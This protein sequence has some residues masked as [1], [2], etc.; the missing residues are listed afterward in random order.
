MRS[1]IEAMNA[2][3]T[4]QRLGGIEDTQFLTDQGLSAS[5]IA[6][7]L[8]VTVRTVERYRQAARKSGLTSSGDRA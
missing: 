8:G 1:T 7:R 4:E 6:K 5:Q 3:R 2:A